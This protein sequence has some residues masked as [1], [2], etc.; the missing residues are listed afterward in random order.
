MRLRP[1]REESWPGRPAG[2]AAVAPGPQGD[3]DDGEATAAT[4]AAYSV[5]ETA[6]CF[7]GP[8]HFLTKAQDG[9]RAALTRLGSGT[10]ELHSEGFG[11]VGKPPEPGLEGREGADERGR[12][13]FR[14]VLT[15][16][17]LLNLALAGPFHS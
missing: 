9:N 13:R 5:P 4:A 16:L 14:W 1:Q 6:Q 7:A 17:F 10:E 8:N 12:A 11:H 3:H 15:F 2:V